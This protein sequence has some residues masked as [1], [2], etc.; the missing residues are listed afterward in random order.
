MYFDV[1]GVKMLDLLTGPGLKEMGIQVFM[2][3]DTIDI[4][5]GTGAKKIQYPHCN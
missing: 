2:V 5:R 3:A 4:V 1:K